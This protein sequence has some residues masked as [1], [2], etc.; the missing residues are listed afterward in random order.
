MYIATHETVATLKV[1]SFTP[2][3]TQLS[4]IQDIE[5]MSDGQYIS[6]IGKIVDICPVSV[7]KIISY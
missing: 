5:S 1:V 4:L 3:C 2:S 6:F 7:Q